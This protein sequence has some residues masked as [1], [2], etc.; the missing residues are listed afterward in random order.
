MR[1]KKLI[2]RIY[3]L[4]SEVARLKDNEDYW[5][6]MIMRFAKGLHEHGVEAEIVFPEPPKI[7]VSTL[8]E[9]EQY[10]DGRTTELP[11]LRFDFTE[12]DEKIKIEVDG[13]E[14]EIGMVKRAVAK[15]RAERI[16]FRNGKTCCPMCGEPAFRQNYCDRC[17]QKLRGE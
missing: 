9:K 16:G 10:I 11:T 6:D 17:G 3:E 8:E 12:H 14:I 2:E 7:N 15:Q 4:E 13:K 1:K 5:K